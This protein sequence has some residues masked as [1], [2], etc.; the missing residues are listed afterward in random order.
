[1]VLLRLVLLCLVAPRLTRTLILL[2][3]TQVKPVPSLGSW[4]IKELR[5]LACL[6]FVVRKI[7]IMTLDILVFHRLFWALFEPLTC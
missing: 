4:F 6:D 2:L 3:V 7:A 5:A 1:M